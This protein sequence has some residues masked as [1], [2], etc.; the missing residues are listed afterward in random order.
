MERPGADRAAPRWG[1]DQRFRVLDLVLFEEEAASPF[2]GL[3]RV[4]L[5]NE[6]R[7]P[8]NSGRNYLLG[9]SESAVC[10]GT[11]VDLALKPPRLELLHSPTFCLLA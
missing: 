4:E 11:R 6:R 2:V 5:A 8:H 3:L 10:W 7:V 9:K 1:L